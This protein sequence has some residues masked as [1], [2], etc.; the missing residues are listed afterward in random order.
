MIK[1]RTLNIFGTI[2]II[3][4][5]IILFNSYFSI[6]G[7]VVLGET[8]TNTLYSISIVF[9]L[10]GITLLTTARGWDR[11]RVGL[12]VKEYESGELNPVQAALKI[13][14]KLFPNGV[15]VNGVDYR[16]GT[17]ETIRTENEHI[18]VKLNEKGKAR[19]LALALYEIALINNR[20]NA[21][22][23]ELHLG[24]QASS[25]HHRKGLKKIIDNFEDK[26]EKDLKAITIE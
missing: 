26:Y 20:D 3:I 23:C 25:K 5:L 14:D 2:F 19:D 7:F 24:K 11:Y 9:I 15:K 13:N 10:I 18:P 21:R 12:V 4:G 1:K 8:T 6:T 16:G 17:K 22:N